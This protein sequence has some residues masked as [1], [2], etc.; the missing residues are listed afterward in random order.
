[1]PRTL[2]IVL[3]LIPLAAA[4]AYGGWLAY[5]NA[6]RPAAVAGGDPKPPD[7]VQPNPAPGPTP[8]PTASPT[9]LVVLV[10]FDQMRGDYPDRW[11]ELYGPDG[12]ER[13]KKGGTWFT[14]CHIPYACTSTGPGHA[15]LSTGAPPAVNGI[16]ENDWFERAENA[17]I[18]CCQPKRLY[19][20][21]PPAPPSK[22]N[23]GSEL[24]FSPERLLAATVTDALKSAS[25]GKAKVVCLSLKDRSA[26]LPGGQKPDAV[27]CFDT[28]DG[29]FQTGMFYRP[30]PHPWVTTFNAAR[31][32]DSWFDKPWERLRSDIDYAKF[33]G[34]DDAAGEG[35]GTN[36]MS[37]LFPH[38]LRG[39][40]AAPGEGYFKAVEYAPYGNELLFALTKSAITAEKL[41]RGDTTDFL[42][43]SFSSNDIAGH[44]WGPD[45]QEVLD[46]TLRS[47]RLMAE[48]LKFLDEQVGQGKYTVLI[49]AD[50]G[51]CPLPEQQK[52]PGAERVIIA[53]LVKQLTAALDATFG[54]NPSGPMV[55]LEPR[56]EVGDMWPWVYL[57]QKGIEA[58]GIPLET[59]ADY[60]RDWLAGRSYIAAVLT[61]KQIETGDFPPGSFGH[62]AKLAYHPERCGDVL[63]C[64]KPGVLIST[65]KTGTS[66]GSPHPYDTHI[67]LI[68]YGAGVN[69]AGKRTERVSSLAVAPILA[70]A[71]GIAPPAT[72]KEPIPAGV[73]K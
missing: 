14:E 60:V 4:L 20:R 12:F 3:I 61:R 15:A 11:A 53:E 62:Q 48:F 57:N 42:S 18:Y 29:V 9:K 33:S 10:V 8:T 54:K 23:R 28:R 17:K 49:S 63:A 7:P 70:K 41:G 27:Y 30:E 16:I 43:V 24:G 68:V 39:K 73:M 1:M 50:H 38:P 35:L 37:R 21:V 69:P 32:V 26:V 56:A 66:H 19:E 59:V 22:S 2:R 55:W 52:I 58:R 47:D 65:Y 46:F 34:P 31:L 36:G 51:I 40:L 6:Q 64:P 71:L 5:Q 72:A 67:P 13:M 25:G 45:S 44:Q